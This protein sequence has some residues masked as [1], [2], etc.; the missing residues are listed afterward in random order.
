[1]NLEKNIRKA[2]EGVKR[3]ILEIKNNLLSIAERQEKLE[4]TIK[5]ST[6]QEA[7]Q[8]DDSLVQISEEPKKTV[9]KKAMKNS[10]KK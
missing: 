10:N 6:V 7:T 8:H 1:M 9:K 5:E 3:D 4:A 2:F